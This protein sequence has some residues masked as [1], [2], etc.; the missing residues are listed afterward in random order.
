MPT[1]CDTTLYSNYH[2]SEYKTPELDA[3]GGKYFQ[4]LIGVFIWAVELGRVEILLEVALLY[5]HLDLQREGHL[6]QVNHIFEYLKKSH[7]Q[8]IFMD[9][10]HPNIDESI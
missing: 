3:S 10:D 2:P 4:D 6:Q 5:T 7:R 9:T 1:R 8:R